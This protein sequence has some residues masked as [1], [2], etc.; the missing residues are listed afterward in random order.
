MR[1]KLLVCLLV[2]SL[3]AIPLFGACAQPAPPASSPSPTAVAAPE[4]KLSLSHFWPASHFLNTEQVPAW[5]K[6]IEAASKGRV[7]IT[8]H[9]GETL[10]K[11]AETYD[12]VVKGITDIGLSVFAYTRGRF[13]LFE[14]W[15]L[16]GVPYSNATAAAVVAWEGY[17]KFKPAELN[18][19]KVLYLFATGPGHMWTKKPVRTLED[20]KGMKIRAT[21]LSA[22]SLEALGAVPVAMGQPEATEALMKGV[23][24]GNLSPLETLKGFKQAELVSYLTM[25]PFIYNTVFFAVMN[26]DKFNALPPDVQQAFEQVNANWSE[27]AGKFWDA[28]MQEGLDYGVK[29]Y[30]LQVI[31]LSAAETAKWKALLT[32]LQDKYIADMTAKSLPGKDV[33][34][35][36]IKLGEKYSQ[37]YK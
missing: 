37:Q 15:E 26:K 1:N 36:V 10:V 33:L 28:H 7:K 3:V 32:P 31:E 34:A 9:P 18:D 21:G 19:S 5:I 27:K 22:K 12:G 13:P 17:K 30:K 23:V 16:P 35:E 20:L 14:A 6:D 2:L 4:I 8:V 25:T 29:D 11:S 24:D